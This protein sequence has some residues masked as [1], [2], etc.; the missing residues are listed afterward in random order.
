[1]TQKFQESHLALLV[2]ALVP[3]ACKKTGYMWREK[4]TSYKVCYSSQ[5]NVSVTQCKQLKLDSQE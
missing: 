2:S 3:F 1:M 4:R 5:F